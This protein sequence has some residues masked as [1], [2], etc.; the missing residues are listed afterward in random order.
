MNCDHTPAPPKTFEQQLA[1][2]SG[3]GPGFDH[4]RIGLSFMILLWHSF[5]ISYGLN[6]SEKL[7]PFPVP[8]LLSALLPLF[9]GL[10]GFLVMGSALRTGNL[11]TFITFRTLRI[12]PALF[13]EIMISA[14][15]LGPIL[16]TYP[17]HSYLTD[18]RFFEY[19]GSLI[20]RVRF[21]LPGLFAN[22]PAPYLVNFA[23]WTVGPEIFCYV[24]MALAILAGVYRDR[25][26]FLI[27]TIIYGVISI[28]A[29]AFFPPERIGEVLPSKILVFSF[30]VGACF[31][32]YREKIPYSLATAV[33]AFILATLLVF[34]GQRDGSQIYSYFAVPAYI[35]TVAVVGLTPLPKVPIL[36]RGDYSYGVYIYGWPVQQAVAYYLPEHREWWINFGI[37]GPIVLCF[38][39]CSWQ[40]IE[41]PFLGLRKRFKMSQQLPMP[42]GRNQTIIVITI[43][44]YALFLIDANSIFPVRQ[45]AKIILAP[46]GL[47][48]APPKQSSLIGL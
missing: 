39:I 31:F 24:W 35:Y 2:F 34:V 13:T 30:L 10:S 47:Y 45:F 1:Q 20:G 44:A 27:V 26:R 33:A 6:Y 17:L 48:T 21:V 43:A 9:F 16:T 19:F 11:K 25:G 37:S 46:V 23:L 40:F 42:F 41:E 4:I 8:P 7:R 22:N 15:V 38:A 5:A 29:D 3:V 32:Q 28:S 36:S 18:P 14:L 12:V